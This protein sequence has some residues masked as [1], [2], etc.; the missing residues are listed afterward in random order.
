[1]GDNAIAVSWSAGE[2]SGVA[3]SAKCGYAKGTGGGPEDPPLEVVVEG[4]VVGGVPEVLVG[5]RGSPDDDASD[6]ELDVE[7]TGTSW[8]AHP[9]RR[10]ASIAS[11]AQRT[12]TP[13][14]AL[15]W[16]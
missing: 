12:A 2:G 14:P 16:A 10:T 1:L 11:A 8:L 5:T 6:G 13:K 3:E 7:V 9:P 4:P 15:Q